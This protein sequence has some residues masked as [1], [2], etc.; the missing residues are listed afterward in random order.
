LHYQTIIYSLQTPGVGIGEDVVKLKGNYGLECTKSLDLKE[1]CNAFLGIETKLCK[2]LK[3][4]AR[5]LLGFELQKSKNATQSNWEEWN[6][7]ESQ[8]RYACLDAFISY[9]LGCRVLEGKTKSD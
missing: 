6:L 9:L 7:K 1:E 3:G 2:G 5:E 4:Y 8:I